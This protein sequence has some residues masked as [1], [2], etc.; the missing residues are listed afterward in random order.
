MRLFIRIIGVVSLLSLSHCVSLNSVSLTNIPKN[1]ENIIRASVE[2]DVL[3]YINLDNNYIEPLA[4]KLEDQCSDGVVSG[5][6]TK[7]EIICLVPLCFFYT[8]KVTA[9]GVCNR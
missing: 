9:S 5:I 6:L 3:F 2:K 8:S 1:R 4:K 7:H